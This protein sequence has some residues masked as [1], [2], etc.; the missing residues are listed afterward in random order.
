VE[1]KRKKSALA[2]HSLKTG[3][4]LDLGESEAVTGVEDTIHVR[5]SHGTE[6]LGVLRSKLS[7]RN[8]R[9]VGRGVNLEG[10][11]LGP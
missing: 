11:L 4:K 3:G 10:L 9:I 2:Q 7:R 6:K 8:N 5:V 1:T